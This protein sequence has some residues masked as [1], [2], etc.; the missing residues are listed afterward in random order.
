MPDLGAGP[1]RFATNWLAVAEILGNGS[2]IE[3]VR[4]ER[5]CTCSEEARL[6]AILCGESTSLLPHTARHSRCTLC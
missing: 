3:L 6:K 2:A 1:T 5:A 4:H